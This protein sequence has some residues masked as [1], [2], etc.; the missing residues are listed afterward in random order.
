MVRVRRR[1]VLFVSVG[2]T[3][4]VLSTALGV[5]A[6]ATTTASSVLKAAK[7]AMA[8]QTGVHLVDS[9]KSGSSS[10][11]AIGDF[12]TK[13]AEETLSEGK[14]RLTLKLTPTYAYIGGNSSGLTTIF[15][16]TA[17]QAKKVG[18]DWISVKAGIERVRR[19][20][21]R[22]HDFFARRLAPGDQGYDLVHNRRRWRSPVRPEVDDRG[23]EFH[24]EA[25]EHD[26]HLRRGSDP[27]NRGN[28]DRLKRLCYDRVL[29]V[30]R[31]RRRERATGRLNDLLLQ[32][33]ELRAA[34]P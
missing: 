9:S 13:S 33:H 22:P 15:G 34:Q 10:I 14:A 1:R 24:A 21:V 8:K 25:V 32:G 27:A 28:H 3:A 11:L 18:K 6:S 4:L 29:E 20:Q 16:L 12:G 30:G 31:A 17:A 2:A 5:A 7:E 23:D 19:V 26:D